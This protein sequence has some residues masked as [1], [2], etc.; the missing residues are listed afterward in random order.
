MKNLSNEFI[1]LTQRTNF[2]FKY[3]IQAEAE[4]I[5]WEGFPICSLTSNPDSTHFYIKFEN[6]TKLPME[7]NSSCSIYKIEN[8]YF[9]G[10]YLNRTQC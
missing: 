4:E 9:E 1:N 10:C 6:N 8:G 5:N 7:K 2:N 3:N